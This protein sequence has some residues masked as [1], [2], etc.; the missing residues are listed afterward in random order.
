MILTL[1]M[2]VLVVVAVP[3]AFRLAEKLGGS[4]KVIGALKKVNLL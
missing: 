2:I 1:A 4:D 3:T